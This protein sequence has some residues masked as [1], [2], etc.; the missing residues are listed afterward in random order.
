MC[1]LV[2]TISTQQQKIF[3]FV[4]FGNIFMSVT[5]IKNSKRSTIFYYNR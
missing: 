3:R 1:V 5:S 4:P 2:G